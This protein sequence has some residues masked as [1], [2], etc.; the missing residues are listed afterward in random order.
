MVNH[1]DGSK[2]NNNAANLEWVTCSENH[3]HAYATGLRV[4][5]GTATGLKLGR[6]SK[7]HNVS[8]DNERG[9]WVASV[10]VNGTS[11]ARRFASEIE[12][13]KHVDELLEHHGIVNRPRNF[14]V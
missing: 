3:L 4:S 6:S 11:H 10:K 7:Y 14:T 13:A 12:A 8:W 5:N 2:L 9:K 1:I